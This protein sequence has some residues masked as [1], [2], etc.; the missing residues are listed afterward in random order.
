MS[1]FNMKS[2]ITAGVP[3]RGQSG[4]DGTAPVGTGRLRK[5]IPNELVYF[6]SGIEDLKGIPADPKQVLEGIME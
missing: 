3:I 2:H 5:E 1:S 4:H 6:P